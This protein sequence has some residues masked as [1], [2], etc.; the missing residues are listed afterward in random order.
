LEKNIKELQLKIKEKDIIINEEKMKYENLNKLI[1]ELSDKNPK[2][3]NIVKL[4]TEN[5]LFRKYNKLSEG[6]KLITINFISS[7][8]EI[9]YSLIAKISEKF[10]KVENMLYFRY[11]KYIESNNYF[12]LGGNK[13]DRNKTL[14]QNN[15]NNND[16]IT[17]KKNK[18]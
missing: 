4:E 8:K 9:D 1:K 6:D 3:N 7:D 5:E 16:V 17:L 14:E 2:I 13:I 18:V 15:I 10:S 12:L 11:P